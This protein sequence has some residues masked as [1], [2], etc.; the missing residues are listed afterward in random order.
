MHK[1]T[2]RILGLLLCLGILFA[3]AGLAVQANTATAKCS[4]EMIPRVNVP[5]IGGTLYLNHG[6]DAQQVVGIGD[7]EH[8]QDRITPVIRSLLSVAANQDWSLGAQALIELAHGLLGHMQVD[9]QGRSVQPISAPA[10]FDAQQ[11]HTQRRSYDFQFDWR[12]SPWENARLLNEFIN[13][14][15]A[16]TGHDEIILYGD[17]QGNTIIMA[18]FAQFGFKGVVHYIGHVSAHNGLSLVGELFNG[19]AHI[20]Q[21]MALEY[22]RN[23]TGSMDESLADIILPL[24]DVLEQANLLLPVFNALRLLIEHAQDELYEQA[25]I[26][27]LGTW[28]ALWSF[29]PDEYYEPA[30]KFMFGDDPKYSDFIKLIDEHH[31]NAGPGMA[32]QIIAEANEAMMV[33]LIASYG[34]SPMPFTP[35]GSYDTDALIDT[36]RQSSGA[37]MAGVGQ[38]FPA[39]YPGN[40]HLSP[41]RRVDAS[42]CLLPEQT[43]FLKYRVHFTGGTGGLADYL[44]NSTAQPTVFSNPDFP[45]FMTNLPDGSFVPTV[46]ETPVESNATLR[47]NLVTVIEAGF[48]M[49]LA[50][51]FN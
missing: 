16:G 32:D 29:V 49:A 51:I 36:A 38:V 26:P 50:E 7:F 37:T 20:G 23:F 47:E 27:L 6:T 43:W 19:N 28:P 44:V 1:N 15:K 22:L 39:G 25:L 30:K 17:S 2:K 48:G 3:G 18:Y 31:Y 5:G 21:G 14:V 40:K 24:V 34:F 13:E 42:T 45:Q 4:C 33:S 35:L 12:M 9:E 41:D 11:D 10:A 46:P 8:L